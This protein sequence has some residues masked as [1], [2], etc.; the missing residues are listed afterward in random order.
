MSSAVVSFGLQAIT[1]L[2]EGAEQRAQEATS[3][4]EALHDIITVLYQ[5]MSQ[6]AAAYSSGSITKQ[7]ALADLAQLK[8]SFW[9]TI[10]PKIQPNRNGCSSG[11]NCPAANGDIYQGYCSGNIGASCCVGCNTIQ[12][13]FYDASNVINAGSGT[14]VTNAI[15]A[16]PKYNDP[17]FP[18]YTFTFNEPPSPTDVAGSVATSVSQL[19]G[20]PTSVSA[21]SQVQSAIGS[22]IM[23]YFAI[24][25]LAVIVVI[26]LARR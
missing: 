14:V 3:E 11:G 20:M 7:Q 25:F 26:L 24:G 4:N 1:T 13:M 10:T 5:A 8:Q 18:A 16:S 21:S 22:P 2:F 15:Q 17:G 23:L 19:L 6:L 9:S 12:K